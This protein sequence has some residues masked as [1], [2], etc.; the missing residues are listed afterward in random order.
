MKKI[1]KRILIILTIT[2][3]IILIPSSVFYGY[4]YSAAPEKTCFSCHEIQTSVKHWQG[5]AHRN[6]KCDECHGTAFSNGYHSLKEKAGMVFSHASGKVPEEIALN[7]Q[8][9]IET[10]ERCTKC[11]RNEYSNW[12]AGGHSAK[13]KDIFLD[14]IH[15]SAERVNPDCLRCHGMFYSGTIYD[16]MDP[17]DK[18]GPW[19]LNDNAKNNQPVIPCMTCHKVHTE[20][21]PEENPDYSNPS[22]IKSKRNLALPIVGF[23]NR[24]DNS[25]FRADFLPKPKITDK[26][27]QIS[28]SDDPRQRVCIQCH[29]PNAWHQSGSSDDRTPT[30]VHEGISCLACHAT[31]S[32]KTD[33]TCKSCHPILS[34]CGI[35]VE[36]MNT[37]FKDS[38]SS[39]NIHFV[40]CSDCHKESR[41][42]LKKR[43]KEIKT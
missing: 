23:Y 31:H 40:K 27:R 32:N 42:E 37:S 41:E 10:M 1:V 20:G 6:I 3:L 22:E 13:Y 39:N 8:Q 33:K 28:F 16:L 17:I 19:K 9:L 38:K 34:N 4:W 15:N 24:P 7:E 30:G 26:E 12:S 5:S 11:H 14:T 43:K 2:G 35:D 21:M 25:F 29:A 18:K 36:T